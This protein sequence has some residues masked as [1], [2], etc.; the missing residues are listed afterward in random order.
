MEGMCCD[1][2][3]GQK[4]N[5]PVQLRR[6]VCMFARNTAR[7]VQAK[8]PKYAN[9]HDCGN[10]LDGLAPSYMLSDLTG[11]ETDNDE[12]KNFLW[13]QNIVYHELEQ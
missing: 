8:I 4:Q 11:A 12:L 9:I 7:N 10:S 13:T 5:Y 1:L 3:G 2:T 6:R